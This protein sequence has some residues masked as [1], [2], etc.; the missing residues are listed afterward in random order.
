MAELLVRTVTDALAE[1]ITDAILSGEW[2][3]GTVVSEVGVA[4]DIG[5]SRPTA[6]SAI[7]RLVGN[8]LLIRGAYRSAQVPSPSAEMVADVYFARALIEPATAAFLAGNPSSSVTE[9]YDAVQAMEVLDED[10]PLGDVVRLDVA[11]HQSVVSA[12][13]SSRLVRMHTDIMGEM[14][15][16]IAN[17]RRNRLMSVKEIAHDHRSI[18]EEIDHGSSVSAR[19]AAIR[20]LRHAR[21]ALLGET[22]GAGGDAAADRFPMDWDR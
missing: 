18:L 4:R 5:V 19:D 17:V 1:Q 3:G 9:A 10:A 22:A 13:K 14:Q 11:F 2:P 20:H 7:E 15:L 21:D 12:V 16:C 8:G 6:K